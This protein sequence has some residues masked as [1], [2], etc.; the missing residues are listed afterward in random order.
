MEPHEHN[1]LANEYRTL[2]ELTPNK[3]I[4]L[5][6]VGILLSLEQIARKKL[7]WL[8]FMIWSKPFVLEERFNTSDAFRE[9]CQHPYAITL[10]K[11]PGIY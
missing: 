11:L 1:A 10:D 3:P 2:R 8:W 9:Q 4:A 7:D 6:E 5:G